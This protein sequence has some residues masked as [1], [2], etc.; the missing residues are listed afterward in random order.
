[1]EVFKVFSYRRET[2][3]TQSRIFLCAIFNFEMYSF[4][5]NIAIPFK[6]AVLDD[7]TIPTD[8]INIDNIELA[9]A[10]PDPI[11]NCDI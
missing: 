2:T 6:K 7:I 5:N 8:G 9:I 1:M 4:V 10:V 11:K 3:L